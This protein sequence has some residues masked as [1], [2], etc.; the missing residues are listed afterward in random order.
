MLLLI[1]NHQSLIATKTNRIVK[2]AEGRPVME[3]GARRA[4]GTSAAVY[5]ARAAIIGGAVGTSCTL[6]A[7]KFGVPASGTM[8]HSWI[9][10]FDSEYEAF[11][12]Y[13]ETYPNGCTLLVDT[14][15]TLK[16][17]VPNAIRVFDE[18][19]KPQGIRPTAVRLDSGDLAYLSK[20]VR[21]MLDQAGYEDCK[22]CVTN[23]LDEY[24]ISSL[25]NKEQK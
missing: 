23:S 5:G 3:F 15:N 8:A 1:I 11:K 25:L 18:V 7:K 4:H 10:S 21:E 20:Q 2:E 12:T 16:S 17:G 22:I 24:L 9:Q 19:L 13:A 6:T 14:Y